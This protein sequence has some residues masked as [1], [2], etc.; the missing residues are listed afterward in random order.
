MKRTFNSLIGL[1]KYALVT[2]GVDIDLDNFEISQ[3]TTHRINAKKKI[4]S[5]KLE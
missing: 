1:R 4:S 3:F 5:E 2:A